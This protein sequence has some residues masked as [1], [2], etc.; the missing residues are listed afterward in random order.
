MT[1]SSA[2]P[3]RFGEPATT[4]ASRPTGRG[5]V[6]EDLDATPDQAVALLSI[7]IVAAPALSTPA[8]A[9]RFE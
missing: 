7:C 9:A 2:S 1:N 5:L 8:A 3:T 4:G 6:V